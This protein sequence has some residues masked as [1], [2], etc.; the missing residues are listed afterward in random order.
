MVHSFLSGF[1]K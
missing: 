1:D